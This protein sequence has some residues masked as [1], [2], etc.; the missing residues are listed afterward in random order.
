MVVALGCVSAAL[1]RVR[2]QIIVE[3][4][5]KGPIVSRYCTA[6]GKIK[7]RKLNTSDGGREEEGEEKVKVKEEEEEE[8]EE[9]E[10]EDNF[11]I[12]G[13]Y[14]NRRRR[15]KET[16]ALFG[17]AQAFTVQRNELVLLG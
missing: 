16:V 11:L 2:M 14:E 10:V 9:E 8:E 12:S 3:V 15:R 1:G 7:T 13:H 17:E 4:E 6:A 5:Y